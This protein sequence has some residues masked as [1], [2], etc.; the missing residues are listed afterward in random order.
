MGFV[1]L[2]VP[3][4]SRFIVGYDNR[5]LVPVCALLGS[6]FAL[7]CDILARTLFAPYEVPVGIIMSFLGRTLFSFF[8]CLN[9]GGGL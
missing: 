6:I 4:A 3:H 8:S 5:L 7:F 1:G 9:R 2:I